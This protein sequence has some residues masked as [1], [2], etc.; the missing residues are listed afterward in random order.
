MTAH[1]RF[2]IPFL[3]HRL[4]HIITQLI[5]T[6]SDCQSLPI[7]TFGAST[8]GAAAIEV[9]ALYSNTIHAVVSRGGRPDLANP[10]LLSTLTT[11]T[12][13]IVGSRDQQVI[14]LNRR[15]MARMVRCAEK[16]LEVV[17]GAT[18]LFEEEG[19]L[20]KVAELSVQWFSHWLGQAAAGK[21]Q[22]EA[23]QT[24]QAAE[25]REMNSGQETEGKRLER[26]E[27]EA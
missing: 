2:D 16:R 3:T 15:S 23:R 20:E 10:S 5:N 26:E 24:Q 1:I 14:E 13:L 9:A 11:P 18:H 21:G 6:V 12:L 25:V 4:H 19:A 8:G 17:E 22:R 27:K 7:G